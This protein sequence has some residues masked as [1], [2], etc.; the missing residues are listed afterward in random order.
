MP[1]G[2]ERV[3]INRIKPCFALNLP[4][5]PNGLKKSSKHSNTDLPTLADTKRTTVS[6][7]EMINSPITI[8]KSGRLSKPPKRFAEQG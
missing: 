8:P 7:K 4:P 3:S 6:E 2:N 1:R 5:M